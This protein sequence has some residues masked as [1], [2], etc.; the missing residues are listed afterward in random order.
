MIV[1]VVEALDGC[2]SGG[3]YGIEQVN[4]VVV[5]LMEQSGSSF[6]AFEVVVYNGGSW[7]RWW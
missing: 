2:W 6:A 5:D 3:I 1:V 4:K 7:C